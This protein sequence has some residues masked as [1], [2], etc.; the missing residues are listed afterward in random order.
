MATLDEIRRTGLNGLEIA[1]NERFG[2]F[3]FVVLIVLPSSAGGRKNYQAR[4]A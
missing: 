3:Q 2:G 4:R 1:K